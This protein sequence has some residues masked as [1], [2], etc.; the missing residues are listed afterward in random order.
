MIGTIPPKVAQVSLQEISP[1]INML[2]TM[3][4]EVHVSILRLVLRESWII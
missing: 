2:A 4:A 1:R 3:K